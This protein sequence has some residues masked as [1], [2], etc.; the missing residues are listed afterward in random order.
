MFNV[1]TLIL[2]HVFETLED[3]GKIRQSDAVSN[4]ADIFPEVEDQLLI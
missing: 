2:R 3:R 1:I 4:D